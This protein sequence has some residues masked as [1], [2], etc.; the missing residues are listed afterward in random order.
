MTK[1]ETIAELKDE[2]RLARS[3]AVAARSLLTEHYD[4]RVRIWNPARGGWRML[5]ADGAYVDADPPREL[6]GTY[7]DGWRDCHAE[8][9]RSLNGFRTETGCSA[10]A[11]VEV[12]QR[13]IKQ[14]VTK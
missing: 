8:I 13:W 5:R 6:A 10:S 9:V 4:P 11:T 14:R 7:V 1:D 12:M 3:D 2:L